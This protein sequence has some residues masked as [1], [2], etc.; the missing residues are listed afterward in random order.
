MHPASMKSWIVAVTI[1]L[2]YSKHCLT[3]GFQQYSWLQLKAEQF[4][5]IHRSPEWGK[6]VVGRVRGR[7]YSISVW[8]KKKWKQREHSFHL[9]KRGFEALTKALHY[10]NNTSHCYKCCVPSSKWYLL[11]SFS[12]N[13]TATD[14]HIFTKTFLLKAEQQLT[15]LSTVH[16]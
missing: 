9:N 10:G 1:N 16:T 11:F 5:K 3:Q 2:T 12:H 7:K 4:L 6:Q 8:K 14:I 13:R 15:R